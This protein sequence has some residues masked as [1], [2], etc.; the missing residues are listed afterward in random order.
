MAPERELRASKLVPQHCPVEFL[1]QRKTL[2]A[3][4]LVCQVPGPAQAP[5][6]LLELVEHQSLALF[7]LLVFQL[8]AVWKTPRLATAGPLETGESFQVCASAPW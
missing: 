5:S 8:H 7:F 2:L 6:D 4:R 1:V 3:S